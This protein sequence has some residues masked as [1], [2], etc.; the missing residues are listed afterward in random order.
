MIHTKILQAIFGLDLGQSEDPSALALVCNIEQI[1]SPHNWIDSTH[2]V[3]QT[4]QLIATKVFPLGTAYTSIATQTR[5]A[6]ERF[7][8]QYPTAPVTLSADAT[9]IGRP[10]LEII[11]QELTSKPGQPQARLEG[12][13]FTA[14]GQHTKT[15]HPTLPVDLFH[16][17][18]LDMIENLV[19]SME[20]GRLQANPELQHQQTLEAQLKSLRYATS[21]QTGHTT[22]QV[23]G[24]A[25]N[26]QIAN[27]DLVM[28]LAMA[29][30]R[31]KTLYP[32]PL[33]T[34]PQRLPG[35]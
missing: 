19:Q 15:S 24:D 31:M 32:Q 12:I 16:V 2:P 7:K 10:A 34:Q 33:P 5:Q 4:W 23:A 9:G 25:A 13:V 8:L 14:A 27:A 30:W 18:K 21:R 11:Y 3:T 22:I 6:I 26:P 17:P 28:A 20:S 29:T 35:F 1:H